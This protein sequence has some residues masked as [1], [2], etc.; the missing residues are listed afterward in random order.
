VSTAKDYIRIVRVV[1]YV[2]NREAV[3]YQIKRSLHSEKLVNYQEKGKLIIRATT[4]NEFPDV[5][6][7]LEQLGFDQKYARDADDEPDV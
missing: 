5:L 3:E 4:L 6:D 1:E 7:E 2:G